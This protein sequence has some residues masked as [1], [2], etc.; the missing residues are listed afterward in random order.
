MIATE[1]KL[2]AEELVRDLSRREATNLPFI[3]LSIDVASKY[4]R[5]VHAGKRVK[6]MQ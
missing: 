4:Y 6:E 2:T 5:P 1:T 3:T